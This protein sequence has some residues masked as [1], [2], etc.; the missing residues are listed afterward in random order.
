MSNKINQRETSSSGIH[1]IGISV[2]PVKSLAGIHL[3]HAEVQ[4]QGIEDDRLYMLVDENGVFITQRKYPQLALIKVIQKE[5][6]LNIIAENQLLLTIEDCNFQ[7][8]TLR[9]KIWQ[10][11]CVGL[12]ADENVNQWFSQYLGFPVRFI[13]Y[14]HQAT[15][16]IDPNYSQPDDIVSFADGFPLLVI[17][18]PS[19]DDLNSK[20]EVPVSMSHFRPNIVVD[21]CD[22][23]AEDE[24]KQIRIGGVVFDAVKRCSRCVLTTVDPETGIKNNKGQP[25]KTLSQY[26]KGD[27]G[28]LFGMNLIPRTNGSIRINDIVEVI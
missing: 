20:L 13:K 22:A 23:F 27:G 10:D 2:Y 12:V 19:L 11:V 17:S 16:P 8:E 14:N 26:R 1:L 21:G 9:V 3:K 28:V 4:P 7:G 18:Q 5:C 25:L 6:S 15:R 24:W